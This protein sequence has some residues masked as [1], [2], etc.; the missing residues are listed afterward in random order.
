MPECSRKKAQHSQNETRR[1]ITSCLLP[2]PTDEHL[3]VLASIIP[4]PLCRDR[5]THRLVNR[6]LLDINHPLHHLAQYTQLG[7]QQLPSRRHFSCHAETVC[8]STSTYST[9][10]EL[11]GSRL[12]DPLNTITANTKP[13]PGAY[14]PCLE[15]VNLNRLCTSFGQF[16]ANM[17]RWGLTTS[18]ACVCE[19]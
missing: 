9:P 13:S 8:G 3:L 17:H 1:I 11:V 2:T 15:W 10:E 14:L 5:H 7:R 18:A 12:P 4:V 6:S 19:T 16:N